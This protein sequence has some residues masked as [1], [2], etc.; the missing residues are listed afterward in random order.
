MTIDEAAHLYEKYVGKWG[1]ES[2]TYKFEAVKD[3][4]VVATKIVGDSETSDLYISVD[5]EVLSESETYETTRF[6]VEHKDEH[7]NPMYYSNEVINVEVEGP[8]KLIGP[9]NLALIGGSIGFYV[10]TVGKTGRAKITITSN[11]YKKKSIGI[12]VK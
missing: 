3:Q 6:V 11:Y 1:L 9:N 5:D 4:L 12:E 7:G 10:K 2:L 8:V